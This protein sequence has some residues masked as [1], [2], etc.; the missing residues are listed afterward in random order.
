VSRFEHSPTLGI[1]EDGLMT[2]GTMSSKKRTD[3]L[4]TGIIVKD[5]GEDIG[6]DNGRVDEGS[7]SE[8][9]GIN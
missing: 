9:W 8:G 2:T 1:V 3:T 4:N 5:A 6:H 7:T